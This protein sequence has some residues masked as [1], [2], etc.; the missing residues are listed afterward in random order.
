M[1]QFKVMAAVAVAGLMMM[2]SCAKDNENGKGNDGLNNES[3]IKIQLSYNHTGGT[4]ADGT[5]IADK[6]DLSFTEGHIFFATSAGVIDRHVGVG[7]LAG[8]EQV[9]AADLIDS[10]AVIEGVSGSATACYILF[11]DV[12]AQVGSSTGITGNLEGTNISAVK[13]MTIPVGNINDASGAV[14]NVPLFGEGTVDTSDAGTTDNGTD[15][16][17]RVEVTINSLASRLQ[18]GQIS[19]TTHDYTDNNGDEHTVTIG[20]FTVEGIYI[21][22]FHQDMTVG[23]TAGT[24]IDGEDDATA[25]SNAAGKVYATGEL[26]EKLADILGTAATGNPFTV[27]PTGVWAYNVF[28]TT[29][30]HIIIKLTDV[31]YTDVNT[32]ASTSNA[33][34]GATQ[35]LTVQSFKYGPGH[36]EAGE[37][38]AAFA[39]NNIY[40]LSGIQFSYK[41]MTHVPYEENMTVLVDVQMMKWL[42]NAIVWNN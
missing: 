2:A 12:N 11:T 4:R 37:P 27:A 36:D 20:G 25:Y 31:S 38:V 7:N 23:S 5:A 1:K 32:T 18:I 15:Y 40:T 41:D 19:A 22:N 10:E 39:A 21:N 16:T 35:F 29:V 30:P 42:D 28:P 6:T 9:S 8:S 17:A 26:G 13:A 24:I 14:A 3:A 34:T 33:V